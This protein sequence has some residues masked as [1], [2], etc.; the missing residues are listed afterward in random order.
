MGK[1][2]NLL[3]N[4]EICLEAIS[5]GIKLHSEILEYLQMKLEVEIKPG[6]LSKYLGDLYR[7]GKIQK[8]DVKLKG[9]RYTEYLMADEVIPDELPDQLKLMMGVAIH[10]PKH[11]EGRIINEDKNHSLGGLTNHGSHGIR[12]GFYSMEI[13]G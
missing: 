12:S 6:L 3:T 2:E 4:L 5:K 13:Y 9:H 7:D 8:R 10:K 11:G 1:K